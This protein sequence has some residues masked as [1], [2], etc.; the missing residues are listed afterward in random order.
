MQMNL[1]FLECSSVIPVDSSL[2]TVTDSH[3]A[4][5]M[6]A[7]KAII[8]DEKDYNSIWCT[9]NTSGNAKITVSSICVVLICYS[10]S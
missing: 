5:A 4:T 9:N 10:R 7:D 3:N 1:P 2:V 6:G 8:T